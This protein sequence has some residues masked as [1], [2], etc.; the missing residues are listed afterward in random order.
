MEL[1]DVIMPQ[2]GES[3]A[4]GTITRWLKQ[5][6]DRVEQDEALFEISTDKV[7]SEIP[8]PVSGYLAEIL[9]PE[10]TTV[11][12]NTK[13]AT[14]SS[15]PLPAGGLPSRDASPRESS[16]DADSD[17]PET[18]SSRPDEGA[19]A[20]GAESLED[21]DAATLRRTR[22]SPLVR[23]IAAE[24]GIDIRTVRGT[25]LSGRVT[26]QDILAHIARQAGARDTGQRSH[27]EAT[28]PSET[29]P[30]R[31]PTP[32]ASPTAPRPDQEIPPQ[33]LVT[34]GPQDEVRPMS[35]MRRLIAEHMTWSKRI[36]AHVATFLEVD[37]TRVVRLREARREAFEEQTGVKLTFMPFI[38]QATL[39]ALKAYPDCN[40]SILGDDVVYHRDIHLGM[41]VALERGLIV[42]VIR[43]ADEKSFLGLARAVQDL[44]VRARTKKL[45]PDEVQGG[46]FSITNYG[47]FGSLGGTP[48]INQPQ[49]AIL[50]VGA[51]QKR[52]WVV[53]SAEGD[54]IAIRSIMM[55]SLSYDHRLVDGATGSRFLAHIQT[56]LET[57]D[58]SLMG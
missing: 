25:G 10:G 38:L 26:K 58:E 29:R 34:P 57:Y 23:R 27:P 33:F 5:V 41:A 30:G 21:Q 24:H 7:D 36:S 28:K 45:H 50:G 49:V 37:M 17:A 18:A 51:I 42:P 8:A 20:S 56:F 48:V 52:P 3:V 2:M 13:V 40:A 14:I 54:A 12:I 46:T 16:T 47:S 11:E 31:P 35:P 39:S 19:E 4:Q 43:N 22:S 1:H 6:G 53:Q 55:L 32:P 44:A 15:E 9:A